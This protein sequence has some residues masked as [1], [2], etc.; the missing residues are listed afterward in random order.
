MSIRNFMP[1]VV[2]RGREVVVD[3]GLG[4]YIYCRGGV[5]LDG[6]GDGE[7][8]KTKSIGTV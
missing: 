6:D 4:G 3:L 8:R 5:V 7:S 2:E 1:G